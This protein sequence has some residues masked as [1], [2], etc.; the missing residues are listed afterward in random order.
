MTEQTS[1]P[2]PETKTSIAKKFFIVV[3]FILGALGIDHYTFH[4]VSGGAEVEVTVTDS[5]I[6][7]SVVVAEPVAVDTTKVDTTKK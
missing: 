4:Y 7:S 5:T 3:A 6:T 1:T 2:T